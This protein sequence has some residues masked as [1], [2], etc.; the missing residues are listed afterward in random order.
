M[1]FKLGAIIASHNPALD[2]WWRPICITGAV[3]D[4]RH[5][6]FACPQVQGLGSSMQ[7]F[8]KILMF[9]EFFHVAQ[10]IPSDASHVTHDFRQQAVGPDK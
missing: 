10:G 9:H 5:C 2:Q 4:K 6:V 1:P 3:G 7:K 8:S